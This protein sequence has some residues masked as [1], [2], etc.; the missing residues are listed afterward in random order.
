M[1]SLTSYKQYNIRKV[2]LEQKVFVFNH[3]LV[4][5]LQS[6]WY[7]KCGPGV[8]PMRVGPALIGLK[9]S[10]PTTALLQSHDMGRHIA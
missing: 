2:H 7:S 4:L 3:T 1:S 9:T 10:R 8:Y 6:Y 5:C